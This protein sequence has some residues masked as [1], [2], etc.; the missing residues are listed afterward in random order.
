MNSLHTA[1]S[2]GIPDAHEEADRRRVD[3]MLRALALFV[4]TA[5]AAG[6]NR[7]HPP[8]IV[9]TQCGDILRGREALSMLVFTPILVVLMWKLQRLAANNTTGLSS[10][11]F[12]LGACILGVGMGMHDTCDL[13][14]RTYR[15]AAPPAMLRSLDFFDNHLGHWVFFAGFILITLAFGLAQTR[16]PL[17]KPLSKPKML[18]FF[19][20]SLVFAAVMVYNL[21][22]ERTARDVF[23]IALALGI[24]VAIHATAGVEIRRLPMLLLLYPAYT[25]AIIVPVTYWILHGYPGG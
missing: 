2:G 7:M 15:Q 1:P 20:F 16:H 14:G 23:V 10:T 3:A 11:L 22:F 13:L 19:A 12:V 17:S 9:L 25:C 24:T 6:F 18:G 5:L 21:M 8:S 4:A